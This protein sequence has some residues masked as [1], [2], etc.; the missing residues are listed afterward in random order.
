MNKI[1]ARKIIKNSVEL[2][3][4]L[5]VA[6]SYYF[7]NR[8]P[9]M[10]VEIVGVMPEKM[11][12]RERHRETSLE[13]LAEILHQVEETLWYIL[14]QLSSEEINVIRDL[15]KEVDRMDCIEFHKRKDKYKRGELKKQVISLKEMLD[16]SGY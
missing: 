10:K 7:N 2:Y 4:R 5:D 14:G 12:M 6:Y 8:G 11:C 9:Y 16:R 1:E 13:Y 15:L 3:E